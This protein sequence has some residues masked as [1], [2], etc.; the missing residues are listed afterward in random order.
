MNN[1]IFLTHA[2]SG[3][4][5]KFSEARKQDLIPCSLLHFYVRAMPLISEALYWRD[6]EAG[7]QNSPYS[8]YSSMTGH[9]GSNLLEL[10]KQPGKA[11]GTTLTSARYSWHKQGQKH[12]YC[13][14]LIY[15]AWGLF[16]GLFLRPSGQDK[17]ICWPVHSEG[18]IN[19]VTIT[20]GMP[21]RG[22]NAWC[23]FSISCC[24]HCLC[25]VQQVVEAR[26]HSDK[27]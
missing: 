10:H 22:K 12:S 15:S 16:F 4:L 21:Y 24:C 25:Q 26:R 13:I 9:F 8:P 3:S 23:L 27:S 14:N 19:I 7:S 2:I 20:P 6:T 17:H 18:G 5:R 1:K 11:G